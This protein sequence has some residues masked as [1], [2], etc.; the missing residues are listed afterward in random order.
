MMLLALSAIAAEQANPT[1]K[2]LVKTKQFLDYVAMNDMAIAMY[3]ASNMIVAVH[4]NASYL[5]KPNMQQG[6]WTLL[7]VSK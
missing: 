1:S 3:Q 5:R 6:G 4:S 2:M 7:P